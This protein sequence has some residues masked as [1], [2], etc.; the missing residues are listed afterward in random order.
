MKTNQFFR[1]FSFVMAFH[2]FC[3]A[4]LFSQTAPNKPV[5]FYVHEDPVVPEMVAEYEKISKEL[6]DNCKKYAI[7]DNWL[8]IKDDN[9]KYYTVAHIDSM[10]DLDKHPMNAL[11]DKIGKEA[12]GNMFKAFDK[13]YASHRDYLIVRM[14]NSYS[15]MPDGENDKPAEYPYRVYHYVYYEPKN[16]TELGGVVKKIKELNEGKKAHLHYNV[17]ASRFGNNENFIMVEEVAKDQAD[18]NERYDYDKKLMGEELDKLLADVKKLS[19]KMEMVKG[20]VRPDLS[21]FAEK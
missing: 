19:R 18:Y 7:Q 2:V 14:T 11:S 3:S 20:Q 16:Q 13:C 10:A 21:Y 6:V 12:Y 15:Y 4:F 17:Y 8:T 5:L 1:F 9:N